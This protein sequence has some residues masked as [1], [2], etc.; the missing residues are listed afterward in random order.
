MKKVNVVNLAEFLVR[1]LRARNEKHALVAD[2]DPLRRELGFIDTDA[3]GGPQQVRIPLSSVV[4]RY[5]WFSDSPLRATSSTVGFWGVGTAK[6]TFQ[7]V[8]GALGWT[9]A[10]LV[11]HI[12][13]PAG[14]LRLYQVV[15]VGD[16]D[17]RWGG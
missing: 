8:L 16:L 12:K 13:N 1:I 3:P 11:T 6:Y 9:E 7:E 5:S 17:E 10:D 14:R 4:S 15:P 2:D